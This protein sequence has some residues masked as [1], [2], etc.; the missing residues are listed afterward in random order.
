MV[1]D[2]PAPVWGHA[3][4]HHNRPNAVVKMMMLVMNTSIATA[5]GV[6]L[7]VTMEGTNIACPM[8]TGS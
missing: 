7:S 1:G 6:T 2:E 5:N 3:Q 4:P 8:T